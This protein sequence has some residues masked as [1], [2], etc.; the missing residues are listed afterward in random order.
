MAPVKKY[1]RDIPVSCRQ[2]LCRMLDVSSLWVTL[3]GKLNFTNDDVQSFRSALYR[4]GNSSPTDEMLTVWDY[5]CHTITELYHKLYEMRHARS[6]MLLKDLVDPSLHR[7]IRE[8][9][10]VQPTEEVNDEPE[11]PGHPQ[12][13]PLPSNPHGL[14]ANINKSSEKVNGLESPFKDWQRERTGSSMRVDNKSSGRG[15]CSSGCSSEL[16]SITDEQGVKKTMEDHQNTSAL[17]SLIHMHYEEIVKATRDFDECCKLGEGSFGTVYHAMINMSH[18]AVKCMKKNEYMGYETME[19]A[20]T[21]QLKELRALV[22]YRH[23]NIV[24][25]LAY[26]MDGPSPCLLYEFMENGSLE[27]NLLCKAQRGPLDW[28][29][30]HKIAEGSANGIN[31]LHRAQDQPLIHGDIKSANI[32]LDKHFEPKIADFGLARLGPENGKT[33][34]YLKTKNAHGTL[35]YLPEEYKRSSKLSTKVDVYSF[36]VVLMEI[37]AGERVADSKRE[38]NKLLTDIIEDAL[39]LRNHEAIISRVRDRKCPDW[40]WDI[41]WEWLQLALTCTRSNFK[42]RPEINET[43]TILVDISAEITKRDEM[44]RQRQDFYVQEPLRKTSEVFSE[45]Y[46]QTNT[47]RY[48]PPTTTGVMGYPA[49]T[50]GPQGTPMR[51]EFSVESNNPMVVGQHPRYG[52][53]TQR[54]P[55]QFDPGHYQSPGY[56]GQRSD[57]ESGIRRQ[58]LSVTSDENNLADDSSLTSLNS[59]DLLPKMDQSMGTPLIMYPSGMSGHPQQSRQYD[60]R[61]Q[62]YSQSLTG[63]GGQTLQRYPQQYQTPAGFRTTSAATQPQTMP[64]WTDSSYYG[65][66]LPVI[67]PVPR[68]QPNIEDHMKQLDIS[69]L[70]TKPM[71]NPLQQGDPR[72]QQA[73]STPPKREPEQN[74]DI[75]PSYQ[76]QGFKDR[77]MKEPMISVINEES[78]E[79]GTILKSSLTT[80]EMHHFLSRNREATQQTEKMQG[81]SNGQLAPS[82]TS[83]S[84]SPATETTVDDERQRKVSDPLNKS[85]TTSQMRQFLPKKREPTE[86][87]EKLP[88]EGIE[89]I[90]HRELSR[91]KDPT[92]SNPT[93]GARVAGPL[94]DNK[95]DRQPSLPTEGHEAPTS[96]DLQESDFAKVVPQIGRGCDVQSDRCYSVPSNMAALVS[97]GCGVATH[98]VPQQMTEPI[99][100]RK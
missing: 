83:S 30:R 19:I 86:E 33:Y 68:H 87:T 27:D 99:N 3:A 69:Q 82:P 8:I 92:S 79:E 67:P 60:P 57:F 63:Y 16:A 80:D 26:C 47:Q 77:S 70:P 24:A 7:L 89:N 44:Q 73:P 23:R 15:E 6:M 31:F 97:Q 78:D 74:T 35:A 12:L 50:M 100:S 66:P 10:G 53:G 5:S 93:G 9:Q 36:G 96:S 61:Q 84:T 85:L 1:I 17:S 14:T 94:E 25:L 91:A 81:P 34:C 41:A 98:K 95:D 18:Y 20:R 29:L 76:P 72:S 11:F 32:L 42:K 48:G 28:R 56:G 45:S 62:F 49:P 71:G 88:G 58:T 43:V 37:L 75:L 52:D 22:R 90:S 39:E 59:N 55:M 13:P 65:P 40:P 4:P 2:D 21:D 46:Y 54:Q 51:R 64:P 38:P